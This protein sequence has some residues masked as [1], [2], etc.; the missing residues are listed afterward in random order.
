VIIVDINNEEI[1]SAY[2][3]IDSYLKRKGKQVSQNDVWIAATCKAT[4]MVLLTSDKDFDPLEGLFL[5]RIRIP[6]S[7]EN[8]LL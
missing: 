8:E 4:G 6:E 7:P 2:G 5:Q 1:L 3:E